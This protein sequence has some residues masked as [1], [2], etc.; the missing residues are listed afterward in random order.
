M[1]VIRGNASFIDPQTITIRSETGETQV[2]ASNFVIATG[3]RNISIPSL[4]L[5]GTNIISS[6]EALE[7]K[8]L[9]KKLVVIGGVA[10]TDNAQVN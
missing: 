8:R 5:N 1:E 4:P 6:T 7:L 9:P 10:L 2:Q 3:S